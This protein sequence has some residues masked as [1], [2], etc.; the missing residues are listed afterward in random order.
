FVNF[1]RDI[2]S[3]LIP[4]YEKFLREAS[5]KSK[6]KHLIA[7]YAAKQGIAF[8]SDAEYYKLIARQSVYA[9]V[10][11]IIFYLTIK[12][13]F[14]DLPDLYEIDEPDLSKRL[15]F[16]FARGREKDWQAV[17]VEDPIEILG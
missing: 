2:V 3:K 17:F 15:N 9:L 1:I 8:P 6:N 14:T 4:N 5:R 7:E 10:T 12:R 16:A 13:Y 11:K